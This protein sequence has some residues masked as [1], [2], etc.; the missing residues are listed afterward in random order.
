MF[1]REGREVCLVYIRT[2]CNCVDGGVSCVKKVNKCCKNV[3]C[4]FMCC[5]CKGGGVSGDR[6]CVREG[7]IESDLVVA[8]MPG[9]LGLL[10]S[11]SRRSCVGRGGQ[12]LFGPLSSVFSGR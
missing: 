4:V 5:W 3:V 2:V 7:F 9:V 8:S 11:R 10:L 12:I 1:V 6:V